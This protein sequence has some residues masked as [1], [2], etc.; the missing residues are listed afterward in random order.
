M[1]S[2]NRRARR[3]FLIA[4]TSCVLMEKAGLLQTAVLIYCTPANVRYLQARVR[5]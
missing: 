2:K 5:S 1:R 3:K 4:V